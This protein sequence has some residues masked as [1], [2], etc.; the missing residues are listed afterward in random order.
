MV[1]ASLA[2]SVG[3]RFSESLLN[4]LDAV[5]SVACLD[6]RWGLL[7]DVVLE[8]T[9]V[10]LIGADERAETVIV[11]SLVGNVCEV[12]HVIEG[13]ESVVNSKSVVEF[14]HEV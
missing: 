11:S 13:A 3:A 2:Y 12:E 6:E 1:K 4:L 14:F 5:S 9:A 8:D 7:E 10:F